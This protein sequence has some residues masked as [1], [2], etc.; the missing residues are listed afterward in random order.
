VEEGNFEEGGERVRYSGERPASKIYAIFQKVHKK[1]LNFRNEYFDSKIKYF[2]SIE[3]LLK[4]KLQQITNECR[5]TKSMKNVDL[6]D[7]LEY[8]DYTEEE[9][10]KINSIRENLYEPVSIQAFTPSERNDSFK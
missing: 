2:S 7:S 1:S 8:Q 3:E 4:S 6:N 10:F 9:S 5:K